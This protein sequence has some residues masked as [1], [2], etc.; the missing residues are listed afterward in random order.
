MQPLHN[1]ITQPLFLLL[2]E[3]FWKEQFYTYDNRCDVLRA[4]LC[5]SHNFFFWR[6][7]GIFLLRG[8]GLFLCRGCVF[9]GGCIFFCGEV[10]CFFVERL[11]DFCVERLHELLCGEVAW[12]L[13]LP[14]SL[15]LHDLFLWR[16]HDFFF[17]ER[18]LVFFC[19]EA[20]WFFLWRVY[21]IFLC[22]EVAFFFVKRLRDFLWRG[23]V[24]F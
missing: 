12:K 15:R 16:L 24:F 20:A 18:L 17:V 8:C 22:G 21:M 19:T 9:F 2:S 1:K 6:G 11:R 5:Y 7:C 23:C 14:H 10:M 3:Y 4:A 13:S